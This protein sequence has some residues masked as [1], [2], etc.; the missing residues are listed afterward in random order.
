MEVHLTPELEK[1]LNDLAEQTGR[2]ADELVEDAITGYLERT[3]RV[4]RQAGQAL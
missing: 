1:K 2:A 4:A 3:R